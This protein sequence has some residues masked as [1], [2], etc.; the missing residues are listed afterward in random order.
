M[1][2]RPAA[3]Q[4]L[5]SA[6]MPVVVLHGPESFLVEEYTRRLVTDLEK[7]HGE[8]EQ[9]GFDGS[10]CTLSSVLDELPCLSY[11][12][13]GMIQGYPQTKTTASTWLLWNKRACK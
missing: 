9:F 13:N 2:R 10:S 1:A 11:A 5:P 7:T 12:A 4:V 3:K 6:G 8:I